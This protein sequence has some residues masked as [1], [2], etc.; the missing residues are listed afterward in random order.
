MAAIETAAGHFYF[1]EAY[2]LLRLDIPVIAL[3]Y[4]PLGLGGGNGT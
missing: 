3:I 4:D 1:R 2:G